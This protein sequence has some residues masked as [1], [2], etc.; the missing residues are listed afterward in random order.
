MMEDHGENDPCR[1]HGCSGGIGILPKR[2]GSCQG[3]VDDM[4]KWMEKKGY[5]SLDEFR[6]MMSRHETGNPAAF[7]RV[8]FMKY[9]RGQKE[10]GKWLCSRKR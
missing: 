2:S 5:G 7:Q 4:K 9:F 6:A 8:Q 1:G 10:W 3:D